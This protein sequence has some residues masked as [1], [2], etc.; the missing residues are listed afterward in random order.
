MIHTAYLIVS[1][2]GSV[3]TVKRRP[4]GVFP[5]EWVFEVRVN[6]PRR[7][8]VEGTIE[9]E[10][11]DVPHAVNVTQADV[12]QLEPEPEEEA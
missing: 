8:I 12:P 6:V 11:P 9:L 3:R 5:G 4:S 1:D 7:P 2:D 10:I